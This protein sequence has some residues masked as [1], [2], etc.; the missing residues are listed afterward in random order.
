MRLRNPQIYFLQSLVRF[1]F[2]RLREAPIDIAL[3]SFFLEGTA[4]VIAG[5]DP[6]ARSIPP[7]MPGPVAL[8]VD[9]GEQSRRDEVDCETD[10]AGPNL[11]G[12]TS[13]SKD[14]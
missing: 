8:Q 6:E 3:A 12:H 11:S 14:K 9:F 4:S 10:K 2:G 13:D 1:C 5:A 7:S